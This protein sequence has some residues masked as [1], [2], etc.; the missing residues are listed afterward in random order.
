MVIDWEPMDTAS[1][2][3]IR[4]SRNVDVDMWGSHVFSSLHNNQQYEATTQAQLTNYIGK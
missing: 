3:F 1:N 2:L 4:I